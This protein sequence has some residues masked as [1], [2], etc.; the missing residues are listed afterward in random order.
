MPET[1]WPRRSYDGPVH[2]RRR[3]PFQGL[4]L[5]IMTLGV[6]HFYFHAVTHGELLQQQGRKNRDLPVLFAYMGLVGYGVFLGWTLFFLP[7]VAAFGVFVYWVRLQFLALD[8]ARE[9]LGL[10]RDYGAGK[11]LLWLLPGALTGVGP[12]IAYKRL[13]E[14]YNVV[15]HALS[16]SGARRDHRSALPARGPSV[17]RSPALADD[18][19]R[20]RPARGFDEGHGVTPIT[21][22]A[23]NNG[24]GTTGAVATAATDA[25]GLNGHSRP[26]GQAA[27][28]KEADVAARRNGV[29]GP[30]KKR[31]PA[32]FS[33]RDHRRATWK[34]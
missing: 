8:E 13:T 2:G 30:A 12:F 10:V 6:Y 3:S 29:S 24:N 25:A 26:G 21:V 15:W 22:G 4:A 28:R 18:P 14:E 16:A 1:F 34:A 20:L 9:H 33:V 23:S 11:F 7:L 19:D 17:A 5:T 31:T 32:A 27:P